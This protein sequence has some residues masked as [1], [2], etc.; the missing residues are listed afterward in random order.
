MEWR[1]KEGR[2]VL[3]FDFF[4]AGGGPIFDFV[5]CLLKERGRKRAVGWVSI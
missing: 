4:S 3:H 5:G 2:V 1:P